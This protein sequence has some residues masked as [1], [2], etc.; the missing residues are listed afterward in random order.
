MNKTEGGLYVTRRT[1]YGW[2]TTTASI[3]LRTLGSLTMVATDFCTLLDWRSYASNSI[4][5]FY[6]MFI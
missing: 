4:E 2:A 6:V 3:R 5:S 1:I